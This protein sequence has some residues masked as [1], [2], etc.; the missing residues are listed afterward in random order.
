MGLGSW[1]TTTEICL[2]G[3][4][5][6]RTAEGEAG[7][8]DLP[9][10]QLRTTFAKLVLD[11]HGRTDAE[12][13]SAILWE[14]ERP[15]TWDTAI[16]GLMTRIRRFLG[17]AGPGCT[18]DHDPSGYQLH[19]PG[20]VVVDVEE[21]SQQVVVAELA[22]GDRR[23]DDAVAAA[24]V[25]ANA[26]ARPF[27]S[28]AHGSWAET[29]RISYRQVQLRSLMV[30]GTSHI[31]RGEP[32]RAVDT[33]REALEAAPLHEASHRLLIRALLASG[34]V[35]E[36]AQ[37]YERCRQL[38]AHELGVTPSQATQRLHDEILHH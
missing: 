25:S 18:I 4:L 29:R 5:R 17:A 8:K 13:L 12:S 21:A 9:G 14:G 37:A 11:R 27:L 23:F 16:R 19:L 26:C 36:A 34:E 28:G 35:A 22:I 20:E 6:V 24:A 33:A 30:L 38:L 31:G 3:D 15:E 2:L 1:N 7:A 10:G 32:T